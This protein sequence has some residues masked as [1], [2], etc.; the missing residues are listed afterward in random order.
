MNE[1][2]DANKTEKT[3]LET[4]AT[5]VKSEILDMIKHLPKIDDVMRDLPLMN[6]KVIKL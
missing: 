3:N 6:S 1:K 4:D 5:E 2:K